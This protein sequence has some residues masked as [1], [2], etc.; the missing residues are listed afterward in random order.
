MRINRWHFRAQALVTV[1]FLTACAVVDG[2][3]MTATGRG[4]AS[5]ATV[6]IVPNDSEDAATDGLVRQLVV[7][8]LRRTGFRVDETADL[9]VEYAFAKRPTQVGILLS[10]SKADGS[11]LGGWR[12]RPIDNDLVSLCRPALHR[13]MLVITDARSGKIVFRGS[14]E[15]DWCG[16]VDRGKLGGM[17]K[18]AI[19]GLRA[20]L[21]PD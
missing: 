1:L 2:P 4:V 14:S 19:S 17:V 11:E 15:D 12:S 3:K 16:D 7:A 8:E 5:G 20:N 10:G 18:A 6:S 13:L 9:V 21:S